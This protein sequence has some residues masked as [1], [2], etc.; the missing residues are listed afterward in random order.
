MGVGI[1]GG[2]RQF[3]VGTGGETHGRPSGVVAANSELSNFDTFGVL[4][5]TLRPTGYDW[6][7]LPEKGRTFTDAGSQDCQ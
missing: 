1:A 3:I 6:A 5:L 2:P 4:A 7:F